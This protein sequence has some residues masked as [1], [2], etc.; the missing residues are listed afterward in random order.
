[1]ISVVIPAYNEA[2]NIHQT[3]TELL[4]VMGDEPCEII[5]VD[6][7]S[8]DETYERVVLFG[9]THV[10]GIRL[11]RRSGS[12]VALRAGLLHARGDAVL[13]I[14]AD[15]QDNPEAVRQMI[16][17]WRDGSQIV[18]ALRQKRDNE[19][20][21]QKYFS[22]AF[23]K[24]LSTLAETQGG[25][26]I[27]LARADFYLLDRQVVDAVNRCSERHSSLFG[28]IA[29][30][31]FRQDWV[32]YARLARRAGQ[33]KW[34]FRARFRLAKD[35]IIAFS[36]LPLKAMTM[37]GFSVAVLGLLYAALTFVRVFSGIPI[38][39]WA[40]LMIAVLV[41]GGL[42]MA[43]LGIIGEYLW[44]TL[45]ETRNRPLFFIEKM[46]LSQKEAPEARS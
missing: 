10:H 26:G 13:C 35:W 33:S 9:Q 28:L 34:N 22:L 15:G 8:G 46:S 36:G 21:G 19:S 2:D 32:E 1:M 25:N 20:L 37:V 3:L 31:G 27:D 16:A 7:H 6:D 17:K 44:R 12:H 18:W 14:S 43:M 39:G 45:D 41:L 42:Q 4:A 38:Q 30:S 5:V 40:S 11:S 24:L 29:W 23:Y